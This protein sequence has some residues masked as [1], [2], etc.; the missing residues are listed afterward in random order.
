MHTTRD[1]DAR[2]SPRRQS[3]ALLGMLAAVAVVAF[4]GSLATIPHTENGWYA[5]ADRVPWSPPNWLFAPAWTTLYICIA[6]SGFVVWR[7]GFRGGGQNNT[8]APV[9][10]LFVIQLILNGLW[11]PLFFAGFPLIGAAAWWIALVDIVLLIV[12]VVVYIVRSARVSH[13][14]AGLF[15]PY[16]L[17]LLFASSLNIGIIVLN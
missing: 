5:T 17:W 8:A 2:P 12:V 6:V 15:V 1:S 16:G 11:T 9:L 7:R 3:L 4:L 14:G 10:R 13:L